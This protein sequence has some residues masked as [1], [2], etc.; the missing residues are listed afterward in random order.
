[1][2]PKESKNSSFIWTVPLSI[3]TAMRPQQSGLTLG[4]MQTP[5]CHSLRFDHFYATAYAYK[6]TKKFGITIEYYRE[7]MR[8]LKQEHLNNKEQVQMLTSSLPA[9]WRPQLTICQ[10]LKPNDWFGIALQVKNVFKAFERKS[11]HKPQK[12]SFKKINP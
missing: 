5:A 11:F 2:I 4:H 7:K 3:D 1:M 12:Q 9:S 8:L 10:I 6:I